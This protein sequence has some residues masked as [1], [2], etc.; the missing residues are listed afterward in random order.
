MTGKDA[1]TRFGILRHAETVWNR[2]GR[3]QGQ[4]DSPLTD[5]GRQG[6]LRW[7]RLLSAYGWDRILCSDL[8]RALETAG[9]LNESLSLPIGSDPRLREQDWGRWSGMTV[10]QL[11]RE[12]SYALA[13]LL[14][15]GWQFRPPE[16]EA[17]L[18][19]YERCRQA[20]VDAATSWQGENVLV[21]THEGTLMCLIYGLSGRRFLPEEPRIYRTKHLHRLHCRD[22]ALYL[23]CLNAL[24]LP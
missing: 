13:E 14:S 4:Q 6:A 15:R 23:D 9:S 19:V 24:T 2:E 20:L 21:V 3:I 10:K 12:E 18:T 7:G 22:G 17:R 11:R 5:E 16:G 1:G 8:G